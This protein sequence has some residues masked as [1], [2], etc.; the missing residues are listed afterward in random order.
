MRPFF[1]GATGMTRGVMTWLL[2]NELA[3]TTLEVTC[4]VIAL[5]E[6]LTAGTT[7]RTAQRCRG[8]S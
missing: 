4:R 8:P 6:A 5:V 2:D 1:L 3:K 7:G